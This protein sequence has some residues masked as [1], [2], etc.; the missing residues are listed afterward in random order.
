M[1]GWSSDFL[2][3]GMHLFPIKS[4]DLIVQPSSLSVMLGSGLTVVDALDILA[5]QGRGPLKSVLTRVVDRMKAGQTFSNSLKGEKGVFSPVFIGSVEI[6][7]R[8]GTLTKDLERLSVQMEHDFSV[9]RNL[10]SATVYPAFVL[11]VMLVVAFGVAKFVL[12]RFADTVRS[13]GAELPLSTRIVVILAEFFESYGSIFALILLFFIA[14]IVGLSRRE[15]ARRLLHPLFLRIP[16]INLFFHDASRAVL[17]RSFG[18]LLDS[19]IPIQEAL[20]ILKRTTSNYVYAQAIG[21]INRRIVAGRR[22]TELLSFHPRL[23]PKMVQNMIGVGESS[24]EMGRIFS[25]LA[26]YFEERIEVR[27]KNFS[28]LFEPILLLIVGAGVLFLALSVILPIYDIT[29]SIS[30]K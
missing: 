1:L 29:S 28:S 4:F 18:T 2:K 27:S 17:F 5:E 7:E 11:T 8:T 15:S 12:P 10:K 20:E 6:G 13:F 30:I 26:Q 16:I 24:G 19:G 25:F 22:L 3:K 14:V 9:R 23:F 21:D